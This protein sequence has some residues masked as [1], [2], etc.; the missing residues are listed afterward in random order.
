MLDNPELI[1]QLIKCD[2]V[3]CSYPHNFFFRNTIYKLVHKILLLD[4]PVL[5]DK[6]IIKK[7]VIICFP[8]C[9]SFGEPSNRDRDEQGH[10]VHIGEKTNGDGILVKKPLGRY[11]CKW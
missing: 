3:N 8:L 1:N 7:N 2:A 10:V 11:R 5:S 9:I 4:F 6:F